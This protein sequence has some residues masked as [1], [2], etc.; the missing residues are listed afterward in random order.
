MDADV[1]AAAGP[2]APRRYVCDRGAAITGRTALAARLR[3]PP[4]QGGALMLRAGTAGVQGCG[5]PWVHVCGRGGRPPPQSRLPVPGRA[6]QP[7]CRRACQSHLTH[8]VLGFIQTSASLPQPCMPAHTPAAWGALPGSCAQEHACPRVRRVKQARRGRG[9]GAPALPKVVAG[10]QHQLLVL[11]VV[12]QPLRRVCVPALG[13]VAAAPARRPGRAPRPAV[14][15]SL[16]GAPA[17]LLEREPAV[18]AC[19]AA[20]ASRACVKALLWHRTR[21]VSCCGAG[22]MTARACRARLVGC[23]VCMGQAGCRAFM[24]CGQVRRLARLA[25]RSA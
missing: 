19:P 22:A 8:F 12:V 1:Q 6:G 11:E 5:G 7:G 10:R 16:A 20:G 4:A 15:P 23:M 2:Q 17:P 21:Q 13:P 9:P 14:R 3:R 25:G 24:V 18:P